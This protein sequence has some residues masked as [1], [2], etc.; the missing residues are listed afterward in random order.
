MPNL[1]HAKCFFSVRHFVFTLPCPR[2]LKFF[3][4]VKSL[5]W[6]QYLPRRSQ[7]GC[8]EMQHGILKYRDHVASLNVKAMWKQGLSLML[9]IALLNTKLPRWHAYIMFQICY[10]ASWTTDVVASQAHNSFAIASLKS[11]LDAIPIFHFQVLSFLS[12]EFQEIL[13]GFLGLYLLADMLFSQGIFLS[14]FWLI[15]QPFEPVVGT[16]K[17]WTAKVAFLIGTSSNNNVGK[18]VHY[19][20]AYCEQCNNPWFPPP[21]FLLNNF[22]ELNFCS[23]K[24]SSEFF[25]RYSFSRQ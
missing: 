14:D 5:F 25:E 18:T 11:Y 20:L 12:S 15:S 17:L 16:S 23:K 19:F 3:C 21:F 8:Q 1:V 13:K 9:G 6:L 10:N 22:K 2:T 24:F 4:I 7:K